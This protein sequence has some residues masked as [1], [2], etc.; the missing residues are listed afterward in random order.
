MII[1]VN[2]F[3]SGAGLFDIGLI[4]GGLQINKAFELDQKACETYRANLGDHIEHCDVTQT[5][6]EDNSQCH[7]MIFTYPCNRYSTIGDIHGVRTGDDLFAHAL[8]FIAIG[9][10]EFYVVEN[11][12]GMRVFP[13]VMEAMTRLK[14]YYVQVFC[15][16]RS[17]MWLPQRRNRLIIIGTRRPFNVRAP[18]GFRRM[19]LSEVFEEGAR[20]TVPGSVLAR[21]NGKYRDLPIISDPANDDIAPAAVAHYAK[22][23]ST[24]LIVDKSYPLGVRPYTVREYA[25]LQGVP[26]W[27]QFPVS[28]TEAY[29]Q[30][31][32]GVSVPV[33]IWVAKEMT[34][35]MNQSSLNPSLPMN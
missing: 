26:D 22:D 3:F 16:V 12:V 35:Y 2:S 25:R 33:G 11:V 6:V 24:R 20:V 13:V 17:D 18:E 1:T 19:R 5:T 14:Q 15:P 27:V 23:K 21:L 32:N 30:I 31:G 28:D 9:A 10:P 7:G 29:R 4:E 34:R 8:R